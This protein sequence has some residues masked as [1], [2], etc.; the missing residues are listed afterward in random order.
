MFN[1][2]ERRSFSSPFPLGR[3]IGGKRRRTMLTR[4]IIKFELEQ[5]ESVRKLLFY[6]PA[7]IKPDQRIDRL[8]VV[9]RDWASRSCFIT[10]YWRV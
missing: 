2:L 1:K 4:A 6:S 7:P 8:S 10:G 5:L 9:D 3:P